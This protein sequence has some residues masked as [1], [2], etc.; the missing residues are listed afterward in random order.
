M[1]GEGD[2]STRDTDSGGELGEDMNRYQAWKGFSTDSF[3]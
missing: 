2:E 3:Q 1:S